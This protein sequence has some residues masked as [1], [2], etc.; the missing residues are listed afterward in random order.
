MHASVHICTHVNVHVNIYI[1]I[2]IYIYII[3]FF[4]TKIL[5]GGGLK[6]DNFLFTNYEAKIQYVYVVKCNA[7]LRPKNM[8]RIV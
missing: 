2:Y 6:V 4:K 8:D 5:F 1:S 3:Y 7:I